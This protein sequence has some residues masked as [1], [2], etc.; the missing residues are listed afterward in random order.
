M[1]AYVSQWR[2]NKIPRTLIPFFSMAS[3]VGLPE[4]VTKE[5]SL[6]LVQHLLLLCLF[7]SFDS[8]SSVATDNDARRKT[9][10][11]F[12]SYASFFFLKKYFFEGFLF[13]LYRMINGILKILCILKINSQE[14][15]N[16]I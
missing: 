3:N 14:F 7:L 6:V 15:T 12:C 1:L 11:I 2:I 4:I 10:S 8:A 5:C 16:E 13:T 9:H